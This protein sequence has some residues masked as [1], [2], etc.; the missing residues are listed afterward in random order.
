MTKPKLF[1]SY[2]AVTFPLLFNSHLFS[3]FLFQLYLDASFLP[4]LSFIFSFY[5]ETEVSH[6]LT[7]SEVFTRGIDRSN[8][9]ELRLI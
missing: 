4:A 7:L 9:Q 8:K 1:L 6:Y 3:P 2:P 5:V